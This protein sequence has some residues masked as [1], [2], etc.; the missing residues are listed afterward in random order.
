MH[1][2]RD[3]LYMLSAVPKISETFL[4]LTDLGT[5]N[6]SSTDKNIF[7]AMKGRKAIDEDEGGWCLKS[8]W[9]AIIK[10]MIFFDFFRFFPIFLDFFRGSSHNPYKNFK[11]SSS[12]N[13]YKDMELG[14]K[15]IRISTFL[16]V[17]RPLRGLSGVLRKWGKIWD[18]LTAKHLPSP[19]MSDHRPVR[20]DL[21][22][23]NKIW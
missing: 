13:P 6:F 21:H 7:K 18:Q 4:Q 22:I 12:H 9:Y 3:F 23:L 8:P 1:Y 19:S 15:I 11:K 14:R 20:E 16:S 10:N 5:K 2:F 17:E